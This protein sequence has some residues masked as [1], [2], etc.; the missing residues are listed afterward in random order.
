MQY[1]AVQNSPTSFNIGSGE[2]T[3]LSSLSN[4]LRDLVYPSDNN[5]GHHKDT[6]TKH[7]IDVDLSSAARAT[8]S[9]ARDFLRWSATT[10]LKNGAAQLLA[11]HLDR[12][13]PHFPQI[14]PIA[15]EEVDYSNPFLPEQ[16]ATASSGDEK[17]LPPVIPLPLDG[18]GILN[19]RGISSCSV[20]DDSTC[21]RESHATL[22][23][24]SECSTGACSPS[25]FDGVRRVAHAS[26]ENC[27]VVLYTAVLGYDPE[28]IQVKTEFSDGE[29]QEEWKETTV[30][31]IAFVPSESTLVKGVIE[32]VPP[33]SLKEQNL[34]PE[35]PY[36]VKV[37][38]LNGYLSHNGWL[39]I[40]VDEAT[41]LLSPEEIFLPKLSPARLFHSSVRKA[42]YIDESFSY[43]P[44][45]EDAQFLAS[46]TS[47]GARK[48]RTVKGPDAKGRE[49]KYKLPEEPQRKAVL[50]VSPMRH[51]PKE[52]G[53]E[54][55]LKEITSYLM[56]YNRVENDEDRQQPR[57][58]W[59]QRKF[60]EQART[61]VNSM[62][63]R[64]PDRN[65]RH[66]LEIKDFIRSKWV[67]HHLKLESGHQL[68]CEWYKEHVRWNADL[69]QLSFAYIMATRELARKLITRQPL[70]DTTEELS[71]RQ[72]VILQ[73]TDA[74]EWYPLLSTEGKGTTLPLHHSQIVPEAI[75]A[76]LQDLPDNEISKANPDDALSAEGSTYY[77]H[78]MSDARMTAS[79]QQWMKARK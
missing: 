35:T 27:D 66:L 51:L 65:L 16:P 26:T 39:L 14:N 4:E 25:I 58:I 79:R 76:N 21:L 40:F 75:P 42:V 7:V 22:P 57:N 13:L 33:N 23:C 10:S 20:T 34:S 68:R 73:L 77:V 28:E 12:A 6:K 72:R 48:K 43:T 70:E 46:E 31:T 8:S 18:E 54:M 9:T 60:Y 62:T 11:W 56:K 67:I 17:E 55:P 5:D 69:D 78:I 30:C 61:F 32:K 29:E 47:R 15:G 38:N 71:L 3:P 64:S 74:S 44:Y 59:L 19:R 2:L 41:K 24:S 50:V 36:N 37:K 52:K 45:P 63:L 53:H 1:E 49:T